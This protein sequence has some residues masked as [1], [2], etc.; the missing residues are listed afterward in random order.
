MVLSSFHHCEAHFHAECGKAYGSEM[1]PLFVRTVD[2]VPKF[3]T[4]RFK[5]ILAILVV[6]FFTVGTASVGLD[7]RSI[8]TKMRLFTPR[9]SVWGAVCRWWQNWECHPEGIDVVFFAF[10]LSGSS[11][12][13]A[14]TW[15]LVWGS[16]WPCGDSTS[17][18]T[19]CH[20]FAG[21]CDVRLIESNGIK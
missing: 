2:G 8:I 15:L 10:Y 4:Q 3:G 19:S 12:C 16:S 20:T 17:V 7:Y 1:G 13:T 21:R 9:S 11:V 14:R 18:V 5:K 6:V